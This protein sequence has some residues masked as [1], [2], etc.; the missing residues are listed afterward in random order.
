MVDRK[1]IEVFVLKPLV[2]VHQ[3]WWSLKGMRRT[4]FFRTFYTE[5]LSENFSHTP[6]FLWYCL[7]AS[8]DPESQREINGKA[9]LIK[10]ISLASDFIK[11]IADSIKLIALFGSA[12]YV[13]YEQN[14][15]HEPCS[16]KL[17]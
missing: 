7:N 16:L 17:T 3:E 15:F 1:K 13:G 4:A 8:F 2:E 11:L 9:L 10:Q 6:G 5:F 12:I 14:T